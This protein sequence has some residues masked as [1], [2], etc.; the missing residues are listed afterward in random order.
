[1]S[2]RQDSTR[3]PPDGV[4]LRRAR[5]KDAARLRDIARTSY[6]RYIERMG[7]EPGPMVDDYDRRVAEDECWVVSAEDAGD[8]G[9][10][11]LRVEPDHLLLDNV[12]VLPAHQGG[13]IGRYLLV[14][15]DQ[16]ARAHD[17]QEVRLYTHVTMVE[18]IAFYGR[19]GYAETHREDRA[20]FSRVFMAKGL[21]DGSD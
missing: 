19:H 15:A 21:D 20:G 3:T 11:V 1:V 5:P 14:F 12:A 2:D 16:R 9:Y 4:A 13:G 7:R 17:R 8:I 18:N 6:A 10:L